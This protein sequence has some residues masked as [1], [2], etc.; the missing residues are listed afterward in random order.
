MKLWDAR[1][2]MGRDK[3]LPPFQFADIAAVR[4]MLDKYRIERALL[5]CR[6]SFCLDIRYGNDLTFSAA[7]EDERLIPCPTV[8]P[9]SR[10]EVGDE[11]EYVRGLVGDGARCVGLFPATHGIALDQRVIG[12]LF[13]ALRRR[14]TPVVIHGREADWMALADLAAAWPEIPIIVISPSYRHRNL[15]PVLRCTPNLHVTINAPFAL[16]HGIEEFV[17]RGLT[18][19]ILFASDFPVAEPGAAIS[20]LSYAEIPEEDR[21]AIAQG[22]LRRLVENVRNA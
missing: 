21:Q 11:D 15:F 19:Q 18:R 2:T 4:R 20:Y 8:V 10:D 6:E 13:D 3:S 7:E 1:V 9:N 16:N 12:P 22:N 17:G 5:T 14:R